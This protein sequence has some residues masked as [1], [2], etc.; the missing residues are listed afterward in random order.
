MFNLLRSLRNTLNISLRNTG[1][2]CLPLTTRFMLNYQKQNF[3]QLSESLISLYS[4]QFCLR[5]SS[6][7]TWESHG[8][9]KKSKTRT[10]QL[11]TLLVALFRVDALSKSTAYH[12]VGSDLT[13]F[14]TSDIRIVTELN[15]V[16]WVREQT[17]PTERP[18]LVDEA[19]GNFCG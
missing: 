4:L 9:V 8:V 12:L 3:L 17:I 16:A 7:C 19:N 6:L 5:F 11:Q 18:P 15:S 13:Q 2:N 10:T 14:G 1:Y